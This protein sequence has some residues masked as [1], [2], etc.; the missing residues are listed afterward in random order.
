MH[1]PNSSGGWSDCQS[2]VQTRVVRVTRG[3]TCLADD[4]QRVHEALPAAAERMARDL[5]IAHHAVL[6]QRPAWMKCCTLPGS[7][8]ECTRGLKS[9]S[10]TT[11]VSQQ[12]AAGLAV[13]HMFCAAMVRTSCLTRQTQQALPGAAHSSGN[14]QG[15]RTFEG[16]HRLHRT[17]SS[18]QYSAMAATR[19]RKLA[20]RASPLCRKAARQPAS[21]V[22]AVILHA[23]RSVQL[24]WWL[25]PG[26]RWDVW[27]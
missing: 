25:R 27:P 11:T 9:I 1:G 10:T 2:R 7:M 8:L 14:R 22:L 18:M 17:S 6:L 19:M 23:A 20:P 3:R 21:T 12:H 4:E 5:A 16:T 26:R 24:L 15:V 13:E